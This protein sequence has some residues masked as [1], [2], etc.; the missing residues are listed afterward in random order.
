[1]S[2]RK[3]AFIDKNTSKN[4]LSKDEN[5][6]M[7][8]TYN[9]YKRGS[10]K[11]SFE[12]EDENRSGLLSSKQE[13]NKSGNLEFEHENRT[14][15]FEESTNDEDKNSYHE[16]E[17]SNDG[18][19]SNDQDYENQMGLLKCKLCGKRFQSKEKCEHCSYRDSPGGQYPTRLNI[20]G[21]YIRQDNVR[22]N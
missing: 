12:V 7:N 10:V 14:E 17:R 2:I 13:E 16:G 19:E 4:Q 8:S 6:H 21:D 1:M 9:M 5:T 15:V 22:Y 20:L 11:G 18:E 3:G